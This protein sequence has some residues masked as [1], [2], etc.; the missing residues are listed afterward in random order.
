MSPFSDPPRIY[1]HTRL[2]VQ[3]PKKEKK[4]LDE[5]DIAFQQKKKAEEAAIKAA[6]DKGMF[7]CS[8]RC[9]SFVLICF[10]AAKG[11]F[12]ML[13]YAPSQSQSARRLN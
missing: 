13:C 7:L 4:E 2:P 12:I 6:R 11:T 8:V 5:E 10:V 9:P 3:A 1:P